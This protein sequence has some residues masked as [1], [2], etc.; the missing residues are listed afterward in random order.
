[1]FHDEAV[2]R[3]R[4]IE[5]VARRK[6][7]LLDA[8]KHVADLK[9]PPGHRLEELVGSRKGQWSVLVNDQYRVCFAWK[10]GDAFNVEITDYH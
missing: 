6:L 2:P 5:R 3:F 4:N 7:L 1:M 9:V 8:A 10:E